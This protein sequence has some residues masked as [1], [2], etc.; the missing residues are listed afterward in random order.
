MQVQQTTFEALEQ[1]VVTYAYQVVQI[2]Q[3]TSTV[4]ECLSGAFDKRIE[5]GYEEAHFHTKEIEEVKQKHE[6]W[7]SFIQTI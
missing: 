4:D 1:F 6:E 7:L 5:C 3:F 2:S